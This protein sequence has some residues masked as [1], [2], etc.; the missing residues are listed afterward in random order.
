VTFDALKGPQRFVEV[1]LDKYQT[2]KHP[3]AVQWLSKHKRFHLHFTPTSSSWLNLVRR[4]FRELTDKNIRRGSFPSVPDLIASIEN[5]L[6][7]TNDDPKPLVWT[8][9]AASILEKVRRDRVALE[10]VA[11]LPAKTETHH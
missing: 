4:F 11:N 6:R 5:Y 2:H 9:T 10:Q 1:V 3:E 7:V 8:A